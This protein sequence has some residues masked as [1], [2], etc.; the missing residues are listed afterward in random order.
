MTPRIRHL[1]EAPVPGLQGGRERERGQQDT[2]CTWRKGSPLRT[3]CPAPPAP[4]PLQSPALSS[5]WAL[6]SLRPTLTSPALRGSPLET[7]D[8]R[9]RA[10]AGLEISRK[11]PSAAWLAVVF[12]TPARKEPSQAVTHPKRDGGL[13]A[14]SGPRHQ[15]SQ[16]PQLQGKEDGR[17]IPRE[18]NYC[19]AES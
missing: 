4:I 6:R 7:G 19:Q 1:H 2:H 15:R 11:V 5:Y 17:A 3:W 8:A 13:G 18:W 16:Q 12:Q 14:S 10:G 9:A